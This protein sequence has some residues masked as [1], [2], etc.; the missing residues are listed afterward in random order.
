M[1]CF[2]AQNRA[3]HLL[4]R[5]P[6]R[7]AHDCR[8]HIGQVGSRG[9][10]GCA[11]GVERALL[12]DGHARLEGPDPRQHQVMHHLAHSGFSVSDDAP[13]HAVWLPV[14]LDSEACTEGGVH[15]WG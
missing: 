6:Q 10:D 11:P 15:A 9:W 14:A 8:T 2:Q 5:P 1:C 4:R 12:A 7:H 13:W 3:M